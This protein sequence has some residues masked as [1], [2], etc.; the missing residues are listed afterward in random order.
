LAQLKG[1]QQRVDLW[2]EEIAIVS[3]EAP[4]ANPG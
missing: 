1:L 3:S 2:L 4:L